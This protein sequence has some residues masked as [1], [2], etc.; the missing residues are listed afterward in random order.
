M[1]WQTRTLT[2]DL[3]HRGLIMG[4]LNV[5]HDSFS[6][7]G[8]F[9]DTAG[10]VAHAR[11][12][13]AE[14]AEIIDVGG[15]STRPG[16]EPVPEAEELRRVLPVIERLAGTGDF[17]LSIDTMKPAVAQAAVEA[18]AGIVN[19]ITGLRDPAMR[20]VV[21]T[22]GAGAIAMHMQGTPRDMQQAPHYDDVVAEI[23]NFFRQ[24]FSA[25]LACG[26]DPMRLA[27]DP[28][29]GFGKT[30]EH[31]LA[32]L[33]NLDAMRVGGRPMVLGVSRKSF[34]GKVVGSSEW[35]DRAWPTVALTSYGRAR[36]ANVFRVHDAR[37]NSEA[38]RMTEAIL[39]PE[40]VT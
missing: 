39:E 31:N 6:D 21:Q 5:T 15:E 17:V 3:A 34:L 20:E 16:A 8:Q 22:T 19:D 10:A 25:C 38:L 1:L 33:R 36:G 12:L 18:G 7:G 27:F 26:I 2:F 40:V 14:G 29:I 13:A 4:V 9:F 32:L 28:G 11:Q 30:V 24:T 23:T 35:A 37:P